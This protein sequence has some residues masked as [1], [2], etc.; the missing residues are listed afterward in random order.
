[1]ESDIQKLSRKLSRAESDLRDLIEAS[2]IVWDEALKHEDIP[3][4]EARTLKAV[5]F[6]ADNYSASEYL[7]HVGTLMKLSNKVGLL[8]FQL[9][10][11]Q[12]EEDK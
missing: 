5:E 6:S 11:L 10:Q 9:R 7:K 8:R 12:L 1:M 3:E 4:A 2:K